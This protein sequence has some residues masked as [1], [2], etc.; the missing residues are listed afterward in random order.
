MHAAFDETAAI[1]VEGLTSW[2]YELNAD[3]KLYLAGAPVLPS[4]F[5]GWVTVKV[6]AEDENDLPGNAGGTDD[7]H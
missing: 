3:S 4:G 7:N 6:W 1:A 2:N 5:D